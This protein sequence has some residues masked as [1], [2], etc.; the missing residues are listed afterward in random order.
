MITM[1]SF[2]Y[3]GLIISIIIS[4]ISC[5]HNKNYPTAFQPELAKAEAMMYRY[6][7]SALHILQGIQPDIP[8]E[9]EQYATWALL[10]TQA[11]YKNQIEQSDSLINIAYSYFTK[12]DNAQRK[13]LALYYKGIL[14]H[15]S[16]HAEDALS[17]YL[18]AATEIEKTNDYQLGFLINSEVGLM[19]LYRK[20]N[21]YA[22]EYFEK[23]HHNAELSNNQTYIAFSFIYIARAFSQKKQYNKAI[24]YYEKAIKIGQVNNY[25]TILASAMNETSFLFLKT[26]ENKK[27]LQYA[28]DCIKIKKTDQRIFSLGDTYRYLKM[29]D[30]AYFYLNQACLSPNIHTARS[31]YQALY[32]ISQE[33]KDYKKAVEY[34]NKLW[35]YQDSIGKTD[36]NKA[37]IEMQ[38]KY[39]QQKIINENNLS[40]IKKDRIIRNVLIALIILSFIIAITNYLY[41]RKIVSQ[42]QEISEKE[43]KIRYFTMKI[44]EN[45]TL[46]NRN[47][48]RIEELTI[49]MEGSLEI[50]EQWKEQNKIRQ[51]IQQQNETLKLENNNLQNHI[52]NYAQ[53]LK[54][55]SKELEAME[56]LSKE[57]Q[58]LHKREAFLCN[59]LIN[60]TE[61]F[62]KLKT[63]KYID[64]QLWQEIKEKI[65]LLFDNYTKRL[66]HQIPSLTDGDIQIC[67]LIKLR[68]SNG[69][70]ANM[71]AISPTSVSKRKLRLKE[72]I[73]QEIGSLGENQS[74]DL[75]LMEY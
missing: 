56:H 52:S 69:D 75:W 59:Q 67:C 47:K 40:Q 42:K 24:E 50:K 61:L 14:R 34:S 49:Q 7:D 30:S 55:K 29:Y 28:K 70:I 32:Y 20:L 13:A 44:H 19:Y 68:F 5:T 1:S 2:K 73:V 72:R 10:M 41:Q 48:M 66:Y 37:L 26:G 31:A 25:P 16:H 64:D 51:E 46:I 63:T 18:E 17:F 45:E 23:A 21:D 27:A 8:S 36:R 3:A 6:P 62:N 60:Q 38:E 39:D 35:F 22:M 54:E 15:E 57:N 74:L 4:L 43:E 11:Q 53:S 58:Y 71:L 65:D 12:H 33:E 9:N